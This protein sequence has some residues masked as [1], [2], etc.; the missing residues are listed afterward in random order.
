MHG[1]S[2]NYLYEF[3][4]C[5]NIKTNDRTVDDYLLSQHLESCKGQ[6]KAKEVYQQLVTKR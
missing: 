1:Y 6:K 3:G 4:I 5:N 2:N